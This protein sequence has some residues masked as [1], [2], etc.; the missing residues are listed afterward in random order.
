M[1]RVIFVAA[2][3]AVALVA[4]GLVAN[5]S[6][7]DDEPSAAFEERSLSAGEIDIV[8]QPHHIDETGAEIAVTLDT[9]SVELDMDLVAASS[10]VVGDERWQATG[11]RGGGPSGH[12]REGVLVFASAG[13]VSGPF[14]LTL[15][16][17]DGPVVARWEAQR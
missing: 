15:D 4:V 13:E 11:W 5:R 6:G 1:R 14:V 10:L 17:F 7:G 9:H 8:L 2:V 3:V 12:H 16:G